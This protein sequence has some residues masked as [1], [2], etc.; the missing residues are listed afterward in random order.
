MAD[1]PSDRPRVTATV[2]DFAYAAGRY[3]P[4]RLAQLRRIGKLTRALA[5]TKRPR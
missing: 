3:A 1:E 5:R 4:R 2:K